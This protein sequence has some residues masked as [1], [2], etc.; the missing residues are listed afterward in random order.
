MNDN[1][2]SEVKC[3]HFENSFLQHIAGV[4]TITIVFSFRRTASV[5]SHKFAVQMPMKAISEVEIYFDSYLLHHALIDNGS[6]Q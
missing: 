1:F 4:Y 3:F 5:A 2:D 6:F